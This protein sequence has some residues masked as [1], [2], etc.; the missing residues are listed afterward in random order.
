[1]LQKGK[2]EKSE[3]AREEVA[4]TEECGGTSKHCRQERIE[5][6]AQADRTRRK[7]SSACATQGDTSF[8]RAS[9]RAKTNSI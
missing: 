5:R 9:Q 6:S 3:E 8:L 2:D 4:E 1:M 7:H